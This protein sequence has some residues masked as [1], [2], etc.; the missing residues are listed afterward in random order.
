MASTTPA[1]GNGGGRA[2][3]AQQTGLVFIPDAIP[4]KN[5]G[6]PMRLI[7]TSDWHLGR[8]LHGADLLPYQAGVPG[9]AARGV[10][11]PARGRGRRR[12]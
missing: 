9:L 12:G 8:T 4:L 3:S 6:A 11:P 5:Y 1:R 7:H 2:G 10:D